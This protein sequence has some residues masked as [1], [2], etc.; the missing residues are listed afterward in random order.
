MEEVPQTL[1]E[2]QLYATFINC[3][4][5]QDNIQYLRHVILKDGI[6][7]DPRMVKAITDWLVPKYVVDI[8]SIMGIIHYYHKFIEVFSKLEYPIISLYKKGVKIVW[9][10]KCEEIFEKLKH[11]LIVSHV[12]KIIDPH[13][14]FLLNTNT[15][16]EG[17]GGVLMQEGH[18]LAYEPCK[19][20]ENERNYVVYKVDLVVVIHALK[21]WR[22][23]LIGNKFT[24]VTNP[25]TLK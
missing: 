21:M 19:L 18:V 24:L 3:E 16:L 15:C 14:D 13:K 20:K 9:E 7:V 17:L 23:Y 11:L 12:F 2:H 1:C 10:Q 22:N 8:R 5:Y 4:L 25:I 6:E